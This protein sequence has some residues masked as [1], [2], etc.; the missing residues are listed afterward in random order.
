MDFNFALLALC[1]CVLPG[2][3]LVVSA[4]R[5][6]YLFTV[7][8]YTCGEMQADG[9]PSNCI[10]FLS[11]LSYLSRET[12]VMYMITGFLCVCLF[13]AIGISYEI[14]TWYST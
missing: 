2:V 3:V 7:G 11:F 5:W 4:V 1:C 14:I 8:P 12:L 6:C 13:F 9:G 10:P